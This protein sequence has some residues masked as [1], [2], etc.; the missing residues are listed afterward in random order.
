MLHLSQFDSHTI[1]ERL[2]SFNKY[3]S[4]DRKATTTLPP[5]I[6]AENSAEESRERERKTLVSG[7]HWPSVVLAGLP[8]H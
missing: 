7:V 6:S 1:N 4:K 2:K 5:S 8:I 3:D